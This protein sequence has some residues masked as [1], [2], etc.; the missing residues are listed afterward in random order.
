PCIA[1][2]RDGGW[3]PRNAASPAATRTSGS[4]RPG[5]RQ[6]T[7]VSSGSAKGRPP[8]RRGQNCPSATTPP[9]TMGD[10]LNACRAA[11]P[12]RA[13]RL[14]VVVGEPPDVI[15]QRSA[16]VVVARELLLGIE[17]RRVE[18]EGAHALEERVDHAVAAHLAPRAAR[19]QHDR[20]Q[21]QLLLSGQR[22]AELAEPFRERFEL[23]G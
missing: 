23:A 15:D 8:H 10:G 1:G 22:T 20:I 7:I 13:G 16:F 6:D 11:G 18:P 2:S 17:L 3:L 19:R 12:G 4:R 21:V 9:V 14:Y 5:W